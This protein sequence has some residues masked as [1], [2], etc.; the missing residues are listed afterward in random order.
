M[1]TQLSREYATTVELAQVLQM[2]PQ[3]VQKKLTQMGISPKLA[4]GKGRGGRVRLWPVSALP[5]EISAGL[6]ARKR[7]VESFPALDSLP[8]SEREKA[9]A[10]ESLLQYLDEY[11]TAPENLFRQKCEL[12]ETFASRYNRGLVDKELL[13]TL[14]AK[15][16]RTIRR[17]LNTYNS[18]PDRGGREKAAALANHYGKKAGKTKI[19]EGEKKILL[20]FWLT[21]LADGFER[22]RTER[23]YNK[24]SKMYAWLKYIELMKAQGCVS[25]DANG[26]P[27]EFTPEFS[28]AT[29]CRMVLNESLYP[30]GVIDYHR[31]GEKFFESHYE[32]YVE[33]TYDFPVDGWWVGDGNTADVFVKSD[34]DGHIFRPRIYAHMDMRS[35]RVF[36][37]TAVGEYL[38]PDLY[39][40]SLAGAVKE[41]GF[42]LP[43]NLMLDN[44]REAKNKAMTGS[45]RRVGRF[46]AENK[47]LRGTFDILGIRPHFT[48]PYHGQS[49]PIERFFRTM[50]EQFYVDFHSYT[51]GS[52]GNKP[53]QLAHVL[54]SRTDLIPTESEFKERLALYLERYNN[55]VHS[56]LDGW[57]PEEMWLEGG[58]KTVQ[59]SRSTF[60]LAFLRHG[61]KRTVQRN[62]VQIF[63]RWY[64]DGEQKLF[65]RIGQQVEAA[66]DPE[67]LSKLYIFTLDGAFICEAGEIEPARMTETAAAQNSEELAASRRENKARRK[68][69]ERYF[70]SAGKS[71]GRLLDNL[72]NIENEN[73]NDETSGLRDALGS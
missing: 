50:K 24:Q 25:V 62:G 47:E 55:T 40:E 7:G 6:I 52:V 43:Q 9:L 15:S 45:A 34:T 4:E 29:A 68:L 30:R 22:A 33:R 41:N 21:G 56:A 19:S 65:A 49:K 18:T 23:K 14:G 69:A 70:K 20:S 38:T 26:N 48:E 61:E 35:R 59:V 5:A 11:F 12:L 27:V 16:S 2:T 57:T 64:C 13:A 46:Y 67:D 42:V 72:D 58:E 36:L 31:E 32:T 44:G 51:G 66:Y 17:Y 3:G 60:A 71:A 37:S 28:Y 10:R 8:Q 39:R 73:E 53:A 1:I 63:D 54:K